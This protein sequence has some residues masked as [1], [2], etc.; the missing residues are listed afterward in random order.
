VQKATSRFKVATEV[1]H[2]DDGCRHD[3]GIAHLAL[4]IFGMV[5]SL[6]QVVTQT[7]YC[8]YLGIHMFLLVGCGLATTTLPENI[9]IF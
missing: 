7:L 1:E 2:S 5:K 4:G 8:Y 6:Q 9:W 3:F